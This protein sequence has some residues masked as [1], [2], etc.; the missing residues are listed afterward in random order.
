MTHTTSTQTKYVVYDRR[1]ARCNWL[2]HSFH[3]NKVVAI[4]FAKGH[5]ANVKT[6]AAKNGN[7]ERWQNF[8]VGIME[9]GPEVSEIPGQLPKTTPIALGD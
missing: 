2:I 6:W 4:E 3:H 1:N 9:Y 8:Q 5:Y 7:E